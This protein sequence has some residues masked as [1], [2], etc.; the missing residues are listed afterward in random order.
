MTKSLSVEGRLRAYL[1]HKEGCRILTRY[2]AVPFTNGPTSGGM[3]SPTTEE[4]LA[5]PCTCGLD[6][7]LATPEPA[8]PSGWHPIAT[9]PKDGTEVVLAEWSDYSDCWKFGVS[10]WRKYLFPEDG[11]GFGWIG[12]SPTHW[13]PLPE[14]KL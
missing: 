9:A 4:I 11:E 2:C 3:R 10:H 7:L 6:A 8:P 12:H 13:M 5:V 1:Q 14:T